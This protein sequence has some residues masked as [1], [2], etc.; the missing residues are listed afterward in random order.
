MRLFL[1]AV[2]AVLLLAGQPAS[3]Y[4]TPTGCVSTFGLKRDSI[5]N[6]VARTRPGQP[7]QI[8]L[9]WRSRVDVVQI[10]EPP[11]QGAVGAPEKEGERRRFAYVPRA[12]FIG[13][14]RFEV[15]VRY[16]PF[17]KT[18]YTLLKIDMDV[19]R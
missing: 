18:Y 6:V 11:A 5:R 7:C 15:Y 1:P 13:H 2:I 12:G 4:A 3:A 16:T 17:V 10:V 14:D 9:G 8:I 19:T